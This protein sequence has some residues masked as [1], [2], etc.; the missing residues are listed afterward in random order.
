MTGPVRARVIDSYCKIAKPISYDSIKDTPETV[1]A[2][3]EHN[4]AWSVTCEKS[5]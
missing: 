2:I 4:M 1:K 5:E 3:E